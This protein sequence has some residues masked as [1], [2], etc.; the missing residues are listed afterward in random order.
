M[1]AMKLGKPNQTLDLKITP[2]EKRM[3]ALCLSAWLQSH[4]CCWSHVLHCSLDS[5]C[6]QGCD[7]WGV[8]CRPDAGWGLTESSCEPGGFAMSCHKD[9]SL[10]YLQIP[11]YTSLKGIRWHNI[12]S[13]PVTNDLQ[14]NLQIFIL[15]MVIS[16][17][18]LISEKCYLTLFSV[19]IFTSSSFPL[20]QGAE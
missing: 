14:F 6:S 1:L 12:L 19:L 4:A 8:Q 16:L 11:L 15:L 20:C 9:L 3:S 5:A 2:K 17:Q 7:Y 10:I 13:L 18:L